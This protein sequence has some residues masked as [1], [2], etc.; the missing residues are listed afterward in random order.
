MN[1]SLK[2][3]IVIKAI[4]RLFIFL[5]LCFLFFGTGP[6]IGQEQAAFDV[7]FLNGKIIDGTGNPWFYGDVGIKNGRIFSVGNLKK[8]EARAVID[9]K[10]KIIAPGFID[11]HCHAYD[12]VADEKVW[13]GKNEERFFAPNFVSQG[14]TTLVSNQCGYSPL[15]IGKKKDLWIRVSFSAVVG[16]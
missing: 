14:V 9:I 1:I 2:E 13:T 16:K 6:S 11:I 8:A 10:G 12:R 7:L 4:I 15:S 5:S 3:G